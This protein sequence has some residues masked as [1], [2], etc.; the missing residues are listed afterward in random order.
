M[1]I[2]IPWNVMNREQQKHGRKTST[3]TPTSQVSSSQRIH[4]SHQ[5]TAVDV[6]DVRLLK[7]KPPHRSLMVWQGWM[8][9]K[10]A[11]CFER[12]RFANFNDWQIVFWKCVF[13]MI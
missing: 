9:W 8:V 1:W 7:R 12:K 6:R 10:K 2:N 11:Y 4:C 5:E 13:L 3:K